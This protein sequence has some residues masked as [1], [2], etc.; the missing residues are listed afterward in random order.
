MFVTILAHL[1][2]CLIDHLPRIKVQVLENDTFSFSRVSNMKK[3]I[4]CGSILKKSPLSNEPAVATATSTAPRQILGGK[5]FPDRRI[6]TRKRDPQLGR[7]TATQTH[8]QLTARRLCDVLT[9]PRRVVF[10]L[11]CKTAS[12]C[13]WSCDPFARDNLGQIPDL[14]H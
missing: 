1:S 10:F 8:R 2:I 3:I 13:N 4:M 9:E 5:R 7:S 11:L 12:L 14:C 6:G